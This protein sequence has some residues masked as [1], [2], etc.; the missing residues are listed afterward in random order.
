MDGLLLATKNGKRKVIISKLFASCI[1]TILAHLVIIMVFVIQTIA[2]YG[3]GDLDVS[4]VFTA[5]DPFTYIT[6][7]FDYT[8]WQYVIVMLGVSL[9][10]C[11]GYCIFVL[12]ISSKCKHSVVASMICMAFAYIPFLTYLIVRNEQAPITNIL[13]FTYSQIISVRTL[14]ST[15]CT[16]SIGNFEIQSVYLSLLL[17]CVLSVGFTVLTYRTFRSHQV[18]N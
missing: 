9:S 7:P 4:F 13:R 3:I 8:V 17:L 5:G 2:V 16:V 10:G 12:L 15:Y 11:I 18:E 6:S 1:V 14:C